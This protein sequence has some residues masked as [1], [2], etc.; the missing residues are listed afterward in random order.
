LKKDEAKEATFNIL[1]QSGRRITQSSGI[2][3]TNRK[4]YRDSLK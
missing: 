1:L 4:H 2:P 3:A